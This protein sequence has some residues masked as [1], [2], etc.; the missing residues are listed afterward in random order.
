MA[1]HF[2]IAFVV[3]IV[4]SSSYAAVWPAYRGDN[5]RSGVMQAQPPLPLHEQWVYA[6]PHPPAP[7]WPAP[8]K[9]DIWHEKSKLRPT[10][11]YDRAFHVVI[12]EDRVYFGSSADD[13]VYCLDAST[14]DIVWRFFT[15]GPVRLAPAIAGGKVY[16]GSDDGRIYCLNADDGREVWRYEPDPGAY[17]IPGNGS[18]ISS[19]PVRSGVLVKDGCAGV[20]PTQKVLLCALNAADGK[21]IWQKEVDDVSAQGYMLASSRHLFV[22]TGRTTPALFSLADGGYLGTLE[23]EGGA[24]ALLAGD[25]VMSGPGRRTTGLDLADMNSRESLVQI[26]GIRAVV[27]EGKAYIQSPREIQAL[28]YERYSVLARK[29]HEIQKQY[30]QIEELRERLPENSQ[31]AQQFEAK[32][33]ALDSQIAELSRLLNACTLWRKPCGTPFALIKAGDALFAGGDGE[34]TA[35]DC[36]NGDILWSGDVKGRAYSL[37]VANNRLFASTDQGCIHCFGGNQGPPARKTRTAVSTCPYPEDDMTA[38]YRATAK[39]IVDMMWPDEDSA[40]PKKG[41]C[42]VLACGNGRLAYE[43]AQR[44]DMEIVGIE[45]DAAKVRAARD[46]LDR[47]SLYGTRVSVHQVKHGALPYTGYFANLVVADPASTPEALD[48]PADEVFRVLRPYG[49]LAAIGR[50]GDTAIAGA[51]VSADDLRRWTADSGADWQIEHPGKGVRAVLRR[52]PLPG[53]GEWTQLYCNSAHTACSGDPLDGPMRIQW[54]GK[55]GPRKMIDRHHR[56]M[57]S[58]FK[59]GRLFIPGDNRIIAADAYNGTPLWELPVPNSRRVA[60]LRNCGH[61]VVAEEYIYIAVEDECWAVDVETGARRFVIKVPQPGDTPRDW[62]YLDHVGNNL[63]GTG[64]KA[65]ASVKKLHKNTIRFLIEGD[66]RP[67]IAGEY[68]FCTDRFTAD[69]HWTYQNGIIMNNGIAIAD[70]RMFFV[71]SH[72]EKALADE[73]GRL[74]VDWFCEQDTYLRSLDASTGELLWEK[75]VE[76]PFQHIMFLN[77][78]QD[79]VV[80]TGT[81][82]VGEFVQYD[83]FAFDAAD[84]EPKWHNHCRNGDPI[85]GSHGEQ[86]QHPVII[87]DWLFS[88]PFAF[89]LQTGKRLDYRF[90]RGGHSCGGLTASQYYMYGRGWN[91]RMYPVNV[92]ETD[93]VCLTKVNRPGCWLNIIPAGGLV[94]IPESSSGCTCAFPMQTSFGLIPESALVSRVSAGER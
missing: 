83:L 11:T 75:P 53:A 89:D 67:M 25:A 88:D 58:L 78:A 73:D 6:S 7:A 24:Y 36:D 17:G 94:L 27:H 26:D 50:P 90:E 71:E 46:A 86:W 91:P 85:N 68:I 31:Q 23:G 74:R 13:Q 39:Q 10:V 84:G 48:Y 43:L 44:T 57:S 35:L 61:M 21:L 47:A 32:L 18:I 40:V 4:L 81:H 8:A 69:V 22:P 54:F 14:G 29:R 59:D 12:D 45:Q 70:G 77:T 65:G 55:P 37:A 93:G 51:K 80:V 76:F 28:D 72:S 49:G 2:L 30:S 62:G 56:P 19:T 87:G 52:G 16:F 20:F 5:A 60:A 42:L 33:Q 9:R 64:M 63:Y 38:M 1:R 34:V 3:W 79:I 41:Y 66:F 92:D 82:N 15:D